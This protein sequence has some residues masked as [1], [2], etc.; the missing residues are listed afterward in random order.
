MKKILWLL[1]LVWGSVPAWCQTKLT[2]Q[3]IKET[4]ALHNEWRAKVGVPP[5][6]WS[7]K[8]AEVALKW[9][10]QLKNEDCAFKH[11]HNPNYGE[12]LF[13][14]TTGF[15]GAKDVVDGWGNEVK[16]YNY[17]KNS[18]SGVCGHYTQVVWKTTKRV[19]CAKVIDC[20]GNDIWVCN[21]DPPG[22]WRVQKPY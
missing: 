16:D 22:N 9:A 13:M 6:E 20:D 14:G 3:E 8:L 12:N 19:G 4:V 11:S 21:Y 18:C 2:Q 1:V 10:K 5:L 7:D 15:Y 17:E